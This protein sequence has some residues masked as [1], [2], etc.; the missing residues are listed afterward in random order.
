MRQHSSLEK[1]SGCLGMVEG[2]KHTHAAARGRNSR[3][4]QEED[5]S[6]SNISQGDLK[7]I[8]MINIGF[9]GRLHTMFNTQPTALGRTKGR[10]GS[11]LRPRIQFTA[12][13]MP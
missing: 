1:V 4:E 2:V 6:Q 12:M 11:I 7:F 10:E 5:G 8:N 9:K 13:G 3:R